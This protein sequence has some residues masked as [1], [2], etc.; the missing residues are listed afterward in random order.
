MSGERETFSSRFAVIMAMA[1]S[2]I[3][4]GNI[5]RFP[6]I[7]G[8]YGGAAFI[9]VYI[10]ASLILAM[11]IFLSE[12]VIGR[13]GGAGAFGSMRRLAPGTPWKWF[14]L[15]T[16]ITPILILGYYCVVGG[17]SVQYLFKALSLDFS[18]SG[19]DVTKYFSAFTGSVWKPLI[20]HTIFVLVMA[21]IVLAGVKK[22]IEAFTKLTM[23]VLFVMIVIIAVFSVSLPGGG[24]GVEYLLRPDFSKINAEAIAAAT[25]QAFYSLSLGVGTILIYSSYMKKEE[26][27]ISSGIGT[28][29]SDMLFAFLAGLAILPAVFSAGIAPSEGPGLV[30]ETLPFIFQ[31][32]G[33]E[34]A[35][36]ISSIAAI[37]FFF[38]ILTAAVTSAIS[39]LEAGVAFLVEEAGMRRPVATIALSLAVWA[40]GILCILPFGVFDALDSVCTTWLMPLGGLLFVIFAGWVIPSDVLREELTQGGTAPFNVKIYPVVRFAI[41]YIAPLGLIAI[42]L[43][44]LI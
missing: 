3:G 33:Q 43:S 44:Q 2:A 26:N 19:A 14:S 41:R 36:W 20:S 37:L 10:L 38:T 24:K 42:L 1:G 17:W 32:M 29:V 11:P 27:I 15:L 16:V 23:P 31:R 18:G 40:I 7:V 8:K 35:V 39:M 13:R 25:G 4:L 22:G 12:S 21:G 9:I 6:Y 34:G 28:A 30:F 5:W